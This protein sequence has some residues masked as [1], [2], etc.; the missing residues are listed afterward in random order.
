MLRS[1]KQF[2][3]GGISESD[4]LNSVTSFLGYDP[5]AL[6]LLRVVVNFTLGLMSAERR[7][8]LALLWVWAVA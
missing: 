2:K 4:F 1:Y 7:L 6:G 3:A 5:G 8:V